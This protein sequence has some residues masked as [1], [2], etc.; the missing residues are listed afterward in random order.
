MASLPVRRHCEGGNDCNQRAITSCEGCK[1]RFCLAHFTE[2]HAQ[3]DNELMD[4]IKDHESIK[5]ALEDQQ[6]HGDAY[7][8]MKR[9]FQWEK[10]AIEKIKKRA[11]ELQIELTGFGENYTTDCKQRFESLSKEFLKWQEESECL[12]TDLAH[13]KEEMNK[14]KFNF[15][16]PTS[17]SLN[18]FS[19]DVLVPNIS[20]IVVTKGIHEV[21]ERVSNNNVQITESGHLATHDQS[22]NAV[23]IRGKS[24]YSTGRHLIRLRIHE[25]TGQWLFL[26]IN[27][28]SVPLADQSHRLPSS[29]GWSSDN[30]IWSNGHGQDNNSNHRIEMVQSD[31]IALVFNCEDSM[32]TMLNERTQVRFVLRVS[33]NHCPFPWQLH[34]VIGEPN[35]RVRVLQT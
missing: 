15:S 19:G 8:L 14:L 28:K 11:R 12:E 21:F 27:S 13:W 7:E 1:R 23:E 3:V 18:E 4:L 10:E 25:T 33:L 32:I 16:T 9:V 6:K 17:V 26:G 20:L 34:V 29:Y 22:N 5:N 2:H 24:D 30:H 35:G 31:V